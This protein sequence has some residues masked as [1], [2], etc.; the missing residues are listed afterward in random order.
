MNQQLNVA[1]PLP[2]PVPPV[3]PVA[4]RK[5]VRRALSGKKVD[6]D[7][8]ARLLMG[9]T[10]DADVDPES[11]AGVEA[12]LAGVEPR[13]WLLLERARDWFSWEGSRVPTRVEDGD[14]V[15]ALV[16][17]A[18]F[19][20]GRVRERAVGLLAASASACLSSSSSASLAAVPVLVLRAGDW[21]PQVR[22]RAREAIG[23]LLAAD[24]DGA[25]LAAAAPMALLLAGRHDGRW[26]ADVVTE[27]LAADSAGPVVER[28]LASA[29]VELRR[30]AH[31][32][33]LDAGKLGLE[34]V[35]RIAL[36]NRDVVIRAR[37]AERASRLAVDAS[38]VP[39]MRR[40]LA[41]RTPLVRVE[42][43]TA[44]DRL[45]E[46]EPLYGALSDRS[47]LVR[48]TARFYLRRRGV[49]EFAD[50]LRRLVESADVTPG[51]VAGLAEVGTVADAELLLPLPSHPRARLAVEALRA[52]VKLSAPVDTAAMLALIENHPSPAVTRQAAEVILH[53]GAAVDADRL[54]TLLAPD[55]PAPTR[56]A[57]WRLLTS[58]DSAW[59]LAVNVM[60]LDDADETLARRARTSLVA[61]TQQQLYTKP[62]G[63]PRDILA[64]HLPK[65][66]A[67]LP[68]RDV[69][70]LYFI[71][72]IDRPEDVPVPVPVAVAEG[73]RGFR[74]FRRKAGRC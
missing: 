51:A 2:V 52:L 21:V 11:L 50:A 64:A 63:Q 5:A 54:L 29:D 6:A 41:S 37:C 7:A 71:G 12:V 45:D 66:D 4:V 65:A 35:V 33:F 28:L 62:A 47:A 68:P 32:M 49:T 16:V 22:E 38:A 48:G 19:A 59:R 46:V 61:A 70:L 58:R 15:P 31:Q 27:R 40:L 43:L 60:L 20:D 8:A 53:R 56:I 74:I 34:Q 72:G 39:A 26:S 30:L 13:F 1:G 17:K 55:R 3:L 18:L 9:I 42:A 57:A 44:L 24:P 14:P 73:R 25:V 10:A 36:T 67:V 69:R 23:A